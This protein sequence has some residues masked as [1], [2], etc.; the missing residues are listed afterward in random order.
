MNTIIAPMTNIPTQA[1]N[2]IMKN[3]SSLRSPSSDGS[4]YSVRN[5]QLPFIIMV[6]FKEYC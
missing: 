4:V 5:E 3:W 1:I 2:R 6:L